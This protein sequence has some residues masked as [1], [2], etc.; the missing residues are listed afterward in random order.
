MVM[1]TPKLVRPMEAA[2]LPKLPTEKAD[3]ADTSPSMVW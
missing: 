3:P 2:N 1:V